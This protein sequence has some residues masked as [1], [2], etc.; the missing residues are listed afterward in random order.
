MSYQIIES[1]SE[2]GSVETL[3]GGLGVSVSGYYAWRRRVPSQHHQTD[4]ALLKAIRGC[5]RQGGSCMAVLV[6]MQR[7][8]NRE[9]A[10]PASGWRG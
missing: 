2:V 6:S 1:N 4:E 3:G 5:I 8:V 10:A 7:Y 9:C